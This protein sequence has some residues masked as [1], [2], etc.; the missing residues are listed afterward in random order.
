MKRCPNNTTKS[1]KIKYLSKSS[2]DNTPNKVPKAERQLLDS[3]LSYINGQEKN[4]YLL[5]IIL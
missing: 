5:I 2:D 3:L 1:I 4:A